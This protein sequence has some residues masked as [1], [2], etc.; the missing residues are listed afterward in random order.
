[1]LKIFKPK[2][3]PTRNPPLLNTNVVKVTCRDY[4]NYSFSFIYML[5]V[6]LMA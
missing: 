5:T 4:F 2:T 1:L 3:G 6:L